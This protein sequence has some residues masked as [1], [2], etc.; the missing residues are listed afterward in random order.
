MRVKV[1]KENEGEKK[2][3]NAHLLLIYPAVYTGE[4]PVK[5]ISS[6][7]RAVGESAF[8]IASILS[9]KRLSWRNPC[10]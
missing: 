5:S 9:Y 3:G 1:R 2:G 7:S 4:R 8:R 6:G 10:T